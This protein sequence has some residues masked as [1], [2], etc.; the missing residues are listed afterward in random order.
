MS[1]FRVLHAELL[2]LKRTL[3][4]R[5]IFIAPLLV[6]LLQFFV[7]LKGQFPPE[8]KL[9]V[10]LPR[11]TLTIWAIF[12]MPLLITLETSLIN[13]IEHSD[14]HWKHIFALPIRRHTVYLAKFVITQALIAG[15]TLILCLLTV[16]VG[17]AS[18]RV[19]PEL[20]NPG[21]VPYGWIAKYALLVWL[22]SWLIIAI[23]TW[24]SIR[25]STF[26]VALGAGIGGTFF[27]LFAASARLGKYYPW[28]LP[29]NVLTDERM[30]AAL[31]LG[32]VGGVVAVVA[33]CFEFARRD[34]A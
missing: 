8:F 12:M 11:T 17:L 32:V 1:M 33:G 27:A 23:Q 4:F 19:R 28:L 7:L 34:V 13:G 16:L 29:L 31:W 9:W 10:M 20:A 21:P 14:K 2:K 6:A 15:S 30:V 26:T 3:A 5:V 18:A 25:W 22:A 24:V